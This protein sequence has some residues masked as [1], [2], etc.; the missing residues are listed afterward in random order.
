MGASEEVLWLS[1]AFYNCAL[2]EQSWYDALDMLAK[3]TGSQFGELIGIGSKAA[4]PFNIMTDIDPGFHPAFLAAG[5]GDPSVNPRVRAGMDAP[6]LKVLAEEDFISPSDYRRNRHYQEFAIPWDVPHICL[7]TLDRSNDGLIGL[8]VVRTRRDG[9]IQPE[10]KALL[11]AVAPHV[12]AAVRT[13]I[14]LENQS[15]ALL[16]RT[17]EGLSIAAFICDRRGKVRS[18]TP[19][20]EGLVQKSDWLQLRA[21]HLIPLQRESAGQLAAVLNEACSTLTTHAKPLVRTIAIKGASPCQ[22]LILDVIRLLQPEH[23]FSFSAHI[24]IVARTLRS[25]DSQQQGVLLGCAFGLTPAEADIAL[26]IARGETIAQIS[27]AR[28]T[29]IGTV[30]MQ[31]KA[32]MVKLGVSRQAEVVAKLALL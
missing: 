25:N 30:R 20:A 17:L 19:A 16:S 24:L 4:I 21:G 1:E 23:E 13:Q 6:I 22:P 31:I 12:R 27:S 15:L 10:Q 14:A 26:R 9:P 28:E 18:M 11:A 5:G 32:V 2:R 29:S 7:S 8:A 3:A